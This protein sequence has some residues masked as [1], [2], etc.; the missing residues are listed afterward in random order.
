M[1]VYPVSMSRL[2]VEIDDEAMEKVMNRYGLPTKRAAIDFALRRLAG[3]SDP[4]AILALEGSGWA[5][6]LDEMRRDRVE[7]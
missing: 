4:F 1:E 7:P 6:D 3:G 2:N 5:G